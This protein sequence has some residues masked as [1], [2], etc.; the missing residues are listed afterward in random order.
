MIDLIYYI[1]FH[2]IVELTDYICNLS[3]TIELY[4]ENFSFYL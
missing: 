2:C 3:K 1:K 4:S